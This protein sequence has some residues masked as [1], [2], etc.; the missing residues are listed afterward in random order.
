[1]PGVGHQHAGFDPLGHA[2]HVTKQQLFG[3]QRGSRNPQRDGVR[4]GNGVGLLQLEQRLPD[5]ARAHRQQQHAQCQRGRVLKALV[6]VG[7]VYV[8]VFAALARG[9]QHHKVS[10]Q[11]RERM[12]T[13]GH[14]ALRLGPYAHRDL[15]DRERQVNDHA[16]PRAA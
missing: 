4:G 12:H 6:A 11:I 13:V 16:Y 3:H 7:V 8:G 10:Y 15:G 2:Q 14:Q 9:G 1:M 5:H